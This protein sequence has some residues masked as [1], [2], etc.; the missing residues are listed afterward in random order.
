MSLDHIKEAA[1]RDPTYQVLL[2]AVKSGQG[3]DNPDL[4][5]YTSVWEELGAVDNLVCKGD[6]VVIPNSSVSWRE[7]YKHPT[8]A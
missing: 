2:A 6:K 7:L 3:K 4:V 5:L 8:V 1:H